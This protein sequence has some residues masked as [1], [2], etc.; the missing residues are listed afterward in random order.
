MFQVE[1]HC[2]E[3]GLMMKKFFKKYLK[4]YISI[5]YNRLTEICE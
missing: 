1:Q 2:I 3:L 4:F 5:S